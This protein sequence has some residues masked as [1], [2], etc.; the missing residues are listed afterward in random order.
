LWD[1]EPDDDSNDG[2]DLSKAE[3]YVLDVLPQVVSD[4]MQFIDDQDVEQ[5]AR[6]ELLSKVKFGPTLTAQERLALQDLVLEYSDL[7]VTRHCDL[8]VI[9]V[10]EH[11]I[12]LTEG[13]RPVRSKQKRMAPEKMSVL[14]AELDRL[15]E[16][17]FITEVKNTEWVSPVVIVPKKG[18]KWRVCVNYKALNKFTKKDR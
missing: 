4:S 13:A 3:L 15:L 2:S 18:G 8:P 7:F 16:G 6:N 11:R 9:T 5:T 14:K 12:E 1:T 17:G 10:D